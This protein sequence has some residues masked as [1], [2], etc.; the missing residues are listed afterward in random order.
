[1]ISS[2]DGEEVGGTK[3]IKMIYLPHTP[4]EFNKDQIT[5]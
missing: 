2:P 4:N 5:K 3:G 1:M